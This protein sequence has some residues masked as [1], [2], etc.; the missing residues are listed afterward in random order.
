MAR[1]KKVKE[2]EEA[3]EE[4][5]DDDEVQAKEEQNDDD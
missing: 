2:A 3:I 5:L 1:Q 4:V